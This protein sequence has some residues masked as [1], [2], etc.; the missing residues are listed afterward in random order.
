[1][2]WSK[3]TM[4]SGVLGRSLPLCMSPRSAN[5][6]R[7]ARLGQVLQPK[8]LLET[9]SR[10]FCTPW[11]LAAARS[12]GAQRAQSLTLTFQ[13]RNSAGIVVTYDQTTNG[14]TV[15]VS[16]DPIPILL[17]RADRLTTAGRGASTLL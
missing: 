14:V 15:T 5:V 3:V 4:V 7:G 17:E 16:Q 8:L 10:H 6:E 1:M 9:T 13:F 12:F 11:P 2:V